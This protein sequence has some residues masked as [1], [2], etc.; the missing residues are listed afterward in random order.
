MGK[1]ER[2]D[3]GI[4]RGKTITIFVDGRPVKAH[5]GETIAAALIADAHWICQTRDSASLGVFCNIGICYGCLMTVNGKTGVKT[6]S[7]MVSD[8]CRIE[9]RRIERR[10][11][12]E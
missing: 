12:S 6:C 9:T 8:G 10:V 11:F 1:A 7:T 3:K 5:N 4:E 2:L